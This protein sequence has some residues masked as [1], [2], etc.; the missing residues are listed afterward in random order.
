MNNRDPDQ[1]RLYKVNLYLVFRCLCSTI[2]VVFK[3]IVSYVD[4]QAGLGIR[5]ACLTFTLDNI[6]DMFSIYFTLHKRQKRNKHLEKGKS[7]LN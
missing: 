6:K 4:E 7:F 2:P 1:G 3:I 5:E